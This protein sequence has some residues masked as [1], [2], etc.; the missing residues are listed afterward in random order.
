MTV[1]TP[2]EHL[3]HQ[4]AAAAARG[5]P[6]LDPDFRNSVGATSRDYQG[7]AVTYAQVAA[8]PTL[9]RVRTEGRASLVVLDEIHHGGDAKS[10]VT[11]CGRPS[12]Q[13]FAGL[14]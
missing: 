6:A 11:E 7:V 3:K 5:R 13:R 14:L 9:H 4:W 8:H 2:T 10:W 12:R 1:V